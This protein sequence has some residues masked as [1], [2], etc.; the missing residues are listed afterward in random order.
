MSNTLISTVITTKNRA[1]LLPRA[2]ESVLAQDY[3]EIELIVVDDGSDTPVQ[4]NV[5]DKRV[6]LIRNEKSVG[7]SAARNIGFR[8]S[9]GQYLCMLDDDDYY[10]PG[11]LSLK[12]S[13]LEE[14]AEVDL[15]F[16]RV[17]VK[18]GQGAQ[19]YY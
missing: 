15:V 11:K 18:D 12:A 5:Q 9:R 2:I 13:Y 17:V 3:P 4:L 7:L 8:A 6:R 19:R 10:L 1:H 14:H 16:S